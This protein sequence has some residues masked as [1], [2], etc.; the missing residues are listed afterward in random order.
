MSSFENWWEE[1]R[2][3]Y[4]YQLI[5]QNQVS[6]VRKN[7][8]LKLAKAAEGQ[9]KIWES[10][11]TDDK[12][13]IFKPNLRTYFVAM[14]INTVGTDKLRYI[15]S[16]MKIRGMSVFTKHPHENMHWGMNAA[17]NIRA[18]IFGINDGLL[19]NMSLILGMAGANADHRIILLSGVA[20]LLAG[21]FSMAAGEYISMRS[22]KDVFK[23]QIDLEQSELELY[24]EEEMEELSLIY[25]A[26]GIPAEFAKQLSECLIKNP[27]TALNTLARE[28]LGLNPDQLGSPAGAMFSSF[29]SFSLGAAIP[30]IPFFFNLTLG[31]KLSVVLT[32]V[33]LFTIGA[34]A[35]LFTNQSAIKGGLRMLFIATLAGAIT[36]GIG[37]WLGVLV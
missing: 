20:G 16:A 5:A 12:A 36:F 30:L 18:A 34:L 28:E 15:L 23:S 31:L 21:A 10:K 9:A 35:S 27:E 37:R 14:L 11:K 22:Q 17:S 33:S 7:L 1:K 25:Q 2:S 29:F 32:A 19:S 6:P 26:R 3:A 4:L 13:W 8:F 24:P